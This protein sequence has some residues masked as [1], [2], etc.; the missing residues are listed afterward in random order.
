MFDFI[1]TEFLENL[2]EKQRQR[3]NPR[4]PPPL[5]PKPAHRSAPTV[6]WADKTPLLHW[7]RVHFMDIPVTRP[8]GHVIMVVLTHKWT[9]VLWRYWWRHKNELLD[10]GLYSDVLKCVFV[11]TF[12]E[13]CINTVK[14]KMYFIS[15][16]VQIAII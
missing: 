5:P 16:L 15:V 13:E 8:W 7:H 3:Q 11:W 9:T 1:I 6:V 14:Q 12:R 4:T 10:Y 2:R